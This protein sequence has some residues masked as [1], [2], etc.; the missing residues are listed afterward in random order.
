[1]RAAAPRA[2]RSS[3][4]AAKP[5]RLAIGRDGERELEVGVVVRRIAEPLVDRLRI[6]DRDARAGDV[7]QQAG[8]RA[9]LGLETVD[10]GAA[11]ADHAV[12]RLDRARDD[13]R[14][15]RAGDQPGPEAM[16]PSAIY[17]PIA[18]TATVVG[19]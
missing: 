8:D 4:R 15:E 9:R 6:V 11:L 10:R 5:E 17:P 18:I 7:D 16:W 12:Q 19:K 2:A 14:R 3:G 13:E 1:M